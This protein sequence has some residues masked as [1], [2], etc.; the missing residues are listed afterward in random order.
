M[1]LRIGI[2]TVSD[3]SSRGERADASGP[4]LEVVIRDQGWQIVRKDILPDDFGQLKA[5]LVE[6]ADAGEIDVI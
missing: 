2:L 3:R 4:A 6:W 1:T 5:A